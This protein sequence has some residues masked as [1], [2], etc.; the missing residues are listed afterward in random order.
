[1]KSKFTFQLVEKV[2][3]WCIL[4][5]QVC[6]YIHCVW[7]FR[8][9]GGKS[10][11]GMSAQHESQCSCLYKLLPDTHTHTHLFTHKHIFRPQLNYST[12]HPQLHFDSK[13]HLSPTTS[14]LLFLQHLTFS[15]NHA[16]IHR[17]NRKLVI[18]PLYSLCTSTYSCLVRQERELKKQMKQNDEPDC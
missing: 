12:K 3:A 1:M 11:V 10:I 13:T 7:M 16:H 6:L 18:C 4:S 17:R 2:L 15:N 5:E 14:P 9:D 8:M